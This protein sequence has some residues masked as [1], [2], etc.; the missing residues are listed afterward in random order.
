MYY[1]GSAAGSSS[2]SSFVSMNDSTY[3]EQITNEVLYGSQYN[4]NNYNTSGSGES[5]SKQFEQINQL[6]LRPV[7]AS[8]VVTILSLF[9]FGWLIHKEYN[10]DL[11][12]RASNL[13]KSAL[14]NAL[15]YYQQHNSHSNSSPAWKRLTS[16]YPVAF[17]CWSYQL[18]YQ[19]CLTGIP[20][21]G[22]RNQGWDG[23]RLKLNLD[24]IILLKFHTLLFKISVVVGVLCT[25]VLLPIYATAGCG[26]HDFETFGLGTCLPV[27]NTT[28]LAKTTFAHIPAKQYSNNCNMTGNE[29]YI[30]STIFS[31]VFQNILTVS[32]DLITGHFS[33]AYTTN[34]DDDTYDNIE[35][36]CADADTGVPLVI[37]NMASYVW[38]RNQT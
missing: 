15:L 17:V 6:V 27:V 21:T 13:P 10:D 22:T 5:Y 14:K 19:Q 26:K 23:P 7:L 28:G 8:I 20:G 9:V 12:P 29:Q 36:T 31:E 2:S 18:T 25:V 37:K 16:F 3:E 35:A 1:N 30:N 4:N 32:G 24:G 11:T 38:V 33:L 34:T